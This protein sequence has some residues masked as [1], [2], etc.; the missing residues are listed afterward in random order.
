[1]AQSRARPWG[2]T[3]KKNTIMAPKIMNSMCEI[4]A[5]DIGTPFGDLCFHVVHPSARA[6]GR[7]QTGS[8]DA[9]ECARDGDPLAPLFG[10]R[11]PPGLGDRAVAP[12]TTFR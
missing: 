4:S 2:S 8:P 1:M 12:A 9:T 10:E 7:Q 3:I 6:H 11:R 5:V